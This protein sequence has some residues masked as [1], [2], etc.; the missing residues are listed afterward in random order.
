[1]QLRDDAAGSSEVIGAGLAVS[2]IAH[3]TVVTVIALLPLGNEE[4]D[5]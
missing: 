5:K 2:Q 3:G 1:M 4:E